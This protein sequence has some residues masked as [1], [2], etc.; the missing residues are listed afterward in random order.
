MKVD[1]NP[2]TV[3]LNA[4]L[5]QAQQQQGASDSLKQ[6]QTQQAQ[7][8]GGSD[9]VELSQQAKKANEAMQALKAMPDTRSEKVAMV[10]MEID[11]GTYKVSGQQV[12]SGM[13]KEA[14]EN[15]TI[16]QK[17]NIKA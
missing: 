14:F 5:R 16:L 11:N 15:D 17:I 4:Y 3:Q 1:G 2:S 9:K 13:L 12:A 7:L 8:V 10:K 6:Q